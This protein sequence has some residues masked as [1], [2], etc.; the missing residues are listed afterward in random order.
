MR[1]IVIAVALLWSAIEAALDCSSVWND[2]NKHQ[3]SNT[4]GAIRLTVLHHQHACSPVRNPADLPFSRHRSTTLEREHQLAARLFFRRRRAPPTNI[5]APVTCASSFYGFVTQVALGTPP[6]R[7]TVLID[8][9]AAF[10]WV[11][12]VSCTEKEGCF[13][14]DG[15]L[16]DPGAS[17]TYRRLP[18]SSASCVSASG[19]GNIPGLCAVQESTCMYYIEYMDNS[20]STG[21]VGTDMLTFGGQDLPGFVFGCSQRYSGVFGRYSGIFGL[22]TGQLSFFSQVVE[23]TRQY[24]AFSYYLPSPTSVGYIQ[25]GAYDEGGLDFTP[26]FTNGSDYYLAL[27]GITVDGCPLDLT[28]GRGVSSWGTTVAACYLDLGA[29]LSILPRQAYERLEDEVAKRIRGYDHIR[30]SPGC[31]DP[32]YLSAERVIPQVQLRFSHGVRLVLDQ[33]KLMFKVGDGRL[34]LGFVPGTIYMLGRMQM[35]MMYA[36][37]DIEKSRMGFSNS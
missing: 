4:S 12:C 8:S 29:A 31:F 18:C 3:L 16:F 14:H 5:S 36:A 22:A 11:Q 37:Q 23:R 26:M 34:C 1:V 21:R 15:P 10:A 13:D 25:V 32:D 9:A 28:A 2:G 33:E 35:Q 17:T 27:T 6:T 24:K 7:E 20:A 30:S 19:N